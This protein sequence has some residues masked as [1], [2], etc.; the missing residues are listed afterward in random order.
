MLV[1][2]DVRRDMTVPVLPLLTASGH[3]FDLVPINQ[4]KYHFD[5]VQACLE[6]ATTVLITSIRSPYVKDG[7]DDPA[8][9]DE[10]RQLVSEEAHLACEGV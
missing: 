5:G 9:P 7:K 2:S 8:F 4:A 1:A 6:Q 10:T 3:A